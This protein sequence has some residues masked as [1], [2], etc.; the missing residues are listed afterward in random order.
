VVA[1]IID[2]RDHHPLPLAPTLGDLNRRWPSGHDADHVRTAL[3]GSI[4]TLVNVV[5]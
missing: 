4:V 2:L 1:H 5:L 3:A